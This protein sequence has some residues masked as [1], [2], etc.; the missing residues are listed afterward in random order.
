MT[1][2][3]DQDDPVRFQRAAG[4]AVFTQQ[5]FQV[6]F[7]GVSATVAAA[8]ITHAA[9]AVTTGCSFAAAADRTIATCAAAGSF[10]SSVAE[11]FAAAIE[12]GVNVTGFFMQ[13]PFAQ[14]FLPCRRGLTATGGAWREPCCSIED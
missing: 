4:P 6:V 10:T 12:S 3:V 1:L 5:L 14:A 9:A 7:L 11:E 13:S 8:A 2:T